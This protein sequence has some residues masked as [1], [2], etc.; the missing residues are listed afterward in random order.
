MRSLFNH[1]VIPAAICLLAIQS[2]WVSASSDA[3][4]EPINYSSALLND[5]IARLEKR[6]ASGESTLKSGE[7]GGYLSS[8]LEALN[9]SSDSQTL[10]FSKTS[11]QPHF[12]GPE[13][14]RALYFN[15]DTYIGWVQGSDMIEIASMDAQK[16]AIFYTLSQRNLKKAVFSRQTDSCLQCHESGVTDH[17]PGLLLRSVFPDSDG[18]PVY[19]AGTFRIS[20]ESPLKE[21]W[22]GWY[23]SGKHGN[24]IHMGN[25][26]IKDRDAPQLTD[27]SKGA[28]VTDL[29]DLFDTKPYLK[30]SSDIVA[31]MVLE[32]QAKAHN[33]LIRANHL[34]RLALRDEVVMSEALG[35]KLSGHSESTISRIKSAGDPLLKYLLFAEETEITAPIEG[36]TDFARTFQ[37]LGPRDKS[38]RSL[39]DFDLKSRMFKYPCSYMIYSEAFDA[40]PALAKDYFWRRLYDLLTNKDSP[41]EFARLTAEDRKAILEILRT[42]KADLPSYWKAEPGIP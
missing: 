10:V 33:L 41:P 36:T 30:A 22:G 4:A 1:H 7:T 23:V 17:I 9:I 26:R 8:L 13:S 34:T 27:M 16:G 21:R 29:K 24:Q 32:H 3:D 19:S 14:P 2:A 28:N 15:D 20:H 18:M 35:R 25:M 40:L 42:T 12:I 5:S 6:L 11:F 39:R 38:G 37:T 31:L